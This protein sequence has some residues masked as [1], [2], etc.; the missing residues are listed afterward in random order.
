MECPKC[1]CSHSN[2]ME[3]RQITF[4]GKKT[5]LRI[6]I[7]RYCKYRYRT[8]EVVDPTI[9]LPAESRSKKRLVEDAS[10][11]PLIENVTASPSFLPGDEG[12]EIFPSV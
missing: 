5:K 4:R 12:R 8:R 1:G 7:C 6:R 9:K 11:T 3:T 2:V 10:T